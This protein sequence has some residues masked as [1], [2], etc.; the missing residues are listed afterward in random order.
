MKCLI[1]VLLFTIIL[2][3]VCGV[4]QAITGYKA[5]DAVSLAIKPGKKTFPRGESVFLDIVV[6]NNNP[7]IV[8]LWESF[9]ARDF[10]IEVKDSKG[11]L[12]PL[13]K[14]GQTVK[15]MARAYRN[16]IISLKKGETYAP[17]IEISKLFE[18]SNP[19]NYSVKTK[20]TIFDQTG[21][22]A[23]ILT[24]NTAVFSVTE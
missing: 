14:Y 6:T 24:S 8:K 20:R 5:P 1:N 11:L 9:P 19:G 3:R 15:Q 16:V 22:T 23:S 4:S 2:L 12:V 7:R 10:E 18:L 13:T 21:K 17:R